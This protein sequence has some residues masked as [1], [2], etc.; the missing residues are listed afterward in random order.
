MSVKLALPKTADGQNDTSYRHTVDGQMLSATSHEFRPGALRDKVNEMDSHPSTSIF[1]DVNGK[2]VGTTKTDSPEIE[3]GVATKFERIHVPETIPV[4]ESLANGIGKTSL[5]NYDHDGPACVDSMDSFTNDSGIANN[6]IRE[7]NEVREPNLSGWYETSNQV[8]SS[9]GHIRIENAINGKARM[10]P[11]NGGW[12]TLGGAHNPVKEV[13]ANQSPTLSTFDEKVRD[14]ASSVSIDGRLRIGINNEVGS[15]G[16]SSPIP[17]IQSQGVKTE[18]HDITEQALLA[19]MN[20]LRNLSYFP[21]DNIPINSTWPPKGFQ[22]AQGFSPIQSSV[23]QSIY[24]NQYQNSPIR[25]SATASPFNPQAQ[26]DHSAIAKAFLAEHYGLRP[27]NS[28]QSTPTSFSSKIGLYDPERFLQIAHTS[29]TSF[30]PNASAFTPTVISSNL[31]S[32]LIDYK[33]LLD[34]AGFST[35][36]DLRETLPSCKLVGQ[37]VND[38]AKEYPDELKSFKSK[39]ILKSRLIDVLHLTE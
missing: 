11:D 7:R 12:H 34:K 10:W 26:P 24:A 39:F 6:A 19:K 30:N 4:E 2:Q 29:S 21:N 28:Q 27:N 25:M 16:P 36:A 22:S 13:L 5:G 8:N 31:P 17:V 14:F 1:A 35:L 9:E 23:P 15:P 32:E 33:G 3:A 38:R 20:A 37:L 18:A